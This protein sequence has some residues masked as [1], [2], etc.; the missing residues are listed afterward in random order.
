MPSYSATI[1]VVRDGQ[2]VVSG[3]MC[4]PYLDRAMD[5]AS[6][7]SKIIKD[8]GYV[9]VTEGVDGK[10]LKRISLEKSLGAAA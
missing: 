2:L 8:V 10:V 4:T 9:A 3:G 1:W 6:K 5:F 7:I